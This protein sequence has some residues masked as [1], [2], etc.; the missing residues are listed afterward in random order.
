MNNFIFNKQVD[1]FFRH[2][3][4]LYNYSVTNS[5]FQFLFKIYNN[6]FIYNY[7][8]ISDLLNEKEIK[9]IKELARNIVFDRY[10][11]RFN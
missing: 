3:L 7:E 6:I 11:N 8:N 4:L 5:F 10:V 1:K 2:F 9:A